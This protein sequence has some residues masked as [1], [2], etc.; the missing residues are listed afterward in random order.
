MTYVYSF[1]HKHRTAPMNLKDLLGG[2]GANLAEMTS[3]LALPVPPGF[4]IS[5][6]AC[7]DYMHGGW[8]DGLDV[9]VA[10]HRAK[11]EK[12][13][14]KRVGDPADPLL[15]SVRS[16]AKF[17]MPG[18]MDTVLN[19][20][21]NDA[22]VEGLAAQTDERFAYD[23]YR[24]F[25]AMYGRIV[26]DVPG[27]EF[28]RLLDTAREWDGATSDSDI[29]ADTLRRLVLRFK[30]VVERHTGA[31]F[32]QD[33]T[34]QLRGAVEAVFRSW[35][36]ARAIAYRDREG[37]S[38]DLGTAVNVQAMVFGNRDDNSGTGVGFT[39]DAATGAPGAYGDFLVNAQG[40]DVVAG[41]RNTE[42]ISAMQ[43]KFPAIHG[44]L[45]EIFDRLERHYRDMC[46]TEFTIEQ[47]HL[48]MLQTRVGKRTGPAALRM[49]VDMT[50]DRRIKLTKEEAVLRITEDHLD[51]VLHP[52]FAAGASFEVLTTGLAAS[53]G[54]A[55]GRA[56]FSADD[57]VAAYEAGERVILVRSETSPEDVHGMAIAEGILTARGGLVSH[58]A[59]VA[60]G[61]G[62]PAVVG[63]DAVRIKDKA[64]TVGST[65][66]SEGDWL[67]LDGTAGAVVLGQVPLAS[68]TTSPEFDQILKWADQIRKGK[69]AV[70]ANADTGVD[71]AR[72]RE[73]GAEGIGLCRTEHMFLGEDRLPVVR[74]MILADTPE[75][76]A[77]ALE[78]LRVV[79]KADFLEILE[80]M[81]GLPVTVRLLDPPLHEFLPDVEELAVKSATVGLDADESKLYEAA[82]EWR[83]QN[84]MLG[85][86]G[87]RLGVVKPG[88]YAMQVRALM[89]AA[90][91]RV[92]A[93]GKPIVE[94]MIPLTIS[95][96]E[97]A[98]AR[99][100]VEGAIAEAG[101][102]P[103]KKLK[104]TIGTMIETPRAALLAG[105][106][107]E[108]ADFFSF[109]TN[110]LTQM[111][112]GFSR[113]DV[114][115]RIMGPYL[116]L[117]LLDANPFDTVDAAGV[118][119]LVRLGATR[120]RKAHPGLKLGVCG[121][122]GGDP[123]SIAVFYAAGLD[124]VSCSPYRVP[125]ARLAAAQAVIGAGVGA[126][127]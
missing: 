76:E 7:R 16:G 31:P 23:S 127:A 56:Y 33:P 103:S 29:S 10:K 96:A 35:N 14:G 94:V 43:E 1:D 13:M 64:F 21:L 106:I 60:R 69:L 90:A 47:G 11:L 107:A 120:G 84:P 61:W 100:W 49:A 78:E 117:G 112:F 82:R 91:E 15:V 55:V 41:I 27:E 39:R 62:K 119:E 40:E 12:A 22:S 97:L 114:E 58:A 8:P 80:A 42:P 50:K 108:V 19:L 18:M 63:A 75:A 46:D 102:G 34:D 81:D 74:R 93:G 105:E 38:H 48:W 73:F 104:V 24:R 92:A 5:T 25:V 122:H 32:P 101:G 17:S 3:V 89:E 87:V 85:T 45:L 37:I 116:E 72:A 52:N 118:G 2:K 9:E 20:G 88:L 126:T 4:T 57:A 28:D 115:G 71:A 113:D 70:R 54:A 44:E 110:D 26:L 79:Q 30:E 83:E 51:S 111:T 65:T 95:R 121:E 59:V 86:R 109:G 68:G 36:G 6:T 98:E 99:G 77:E 125:I 66:V 123:A 67:S 53:P 124:Y